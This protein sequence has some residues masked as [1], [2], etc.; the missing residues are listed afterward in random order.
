MV[1]FFP[2]S[3]QSIMKETLASSLGK[4]LAD[5]ATNYYSNKAIEKVMND[6]ALKNAPLSERYDRLESALRPFGEYGQ[7]VLQRR[8]GI[9]QQRKGEQMFQK[10]RDVAKDPKANFSDVTFALMEA[11]QGVPGAEKYVGQ[12]LQT[13]AQQRQIDQAQ[14]IDPS[15]NGGKGNESGSERDPNFVQNNAP[16][17]A[18][19]P[20][21]AQSQQDINQQATQTNPFY[22]NNQMGRE[23]PGNAPQPVTEGQVRPVPTPEQ[24]LEQAKD[25]SR[26]FNLPIQDTI[27]LVDNMAKNIEEYNSKVEGD[28]INRIAGQERVGGQAVEKLLNVFP[29]ATDEQQ[30]I[31]RKKGEEAD[32]QFKSQAE[33]DRYLAKEA[34]KFKNTI[35]NVKA[36]IPA[37]RSFNLPKQQFL[38]NDRSFEQARGDLRL[39]LAPLL[40]EGLYDTARLLLSEKGYYPE[41]RESILT[42]LSE[43][44]LKVVAQMPQLKPVEKEVIVPE[45]PFAVPKM[46]NRLDVKDR[47]TAENYLQEALKADP[48]ANLVLLRKAFEEKGVDWRTFKDG[49]NR[50]YENGQLDLDDDQRNMLDVLDEPPLTNLGKFLHQIK[51][52][53]R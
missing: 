20:Q 19:L 30:A 14:N 13:L 51:F 33:K 3:R 4:G 5:F 45:S 35:A 10:A 34:T 38:G 47:L 36:S 16:Q 24:R 50:L 44:S 21:F 26:R 37:G 12:A 7:N 17:R 9:E 40:K 53:G 2:A 11:A 43:P 42:D 1:Q 25:L 46:V 48:R 22:P 32:R 39:K 29:E 18:P 31:F 52:V 27:P 23:E 15:F 8:L 49:I 28:R 6:P 41:E